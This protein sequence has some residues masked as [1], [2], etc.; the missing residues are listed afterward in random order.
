MLYMQGLI[1]QLRGGGQFYQLLMGEGRGG[2]VNWTKI[3]EQV[4]K[5][6]KI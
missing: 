4:D 5:P 2:G 6:M 3:N 1:S